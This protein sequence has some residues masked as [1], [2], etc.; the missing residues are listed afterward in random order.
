MR[1]LGSGKPPTYQIGAWVSPVGSSVGSGAKPRPPTFGAFL[2]LHVSSP[3]VLLSNN[4]VQCSKWKTK[5]PGRPN[6]S[7]APC[8]CPFFHCLIQTPQLEGAALPSLPFLVFHFTSLLCFLFLSLPTLRSRPPKI[9][10][11]VGK[12]CE[13]PSEVCSRASTEI[14]FGTF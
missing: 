14:E 4:Y 12:R 13:L 11:L 7:S 6:P 2:V 9:A 10:T 8:L 5:V 1:F 3:A